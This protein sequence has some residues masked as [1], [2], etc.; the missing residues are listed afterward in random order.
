VRRVPRYAVNA[1]AGRRVRPCTNEG[2]GVGGAGGEGVCGGGHEVGKRQPGHS[3]L[4]N[5]ELSPAFL[6]FV[7]RHPTRVLLPDPYC[8]TLTRHA[9][10]GRRCAARACGH[11]PA[12]GRPPAWGRRARGTNGRTDGSRALFVSL[13]RNSNMLCSSRS[14][15]KLVF[16][17]VNRN[18]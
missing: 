6:I 14:R 13:V 5:S 2:V 8:L 10:R 15:V 3:A 11:R 17:V 1:Q 4:L 9:N 12:L 18:R 7:P 16:T